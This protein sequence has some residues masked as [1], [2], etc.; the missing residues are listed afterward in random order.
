MPLQLCLKHQPQ[1]LGKHPYRKTTLQNS[2]YLQEEEEG[3]EKPKHQLPQHDAASDC[4]RWDQVEEEQEKEEEKEVCQLARVHSGQ[5]RS[6]EEE[7]QEIQ[8][9][10][11]V[12]SM[13]LQHASD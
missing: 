12:S 7:E 9:G 6:Q 13:A 8:T 3:Q 2:N 5:E 1:A 4:A 11:T 10:K